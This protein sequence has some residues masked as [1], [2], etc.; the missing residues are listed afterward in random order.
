MARKEKERKLFSWC[1]PCSL[2]LSMACGELLGGALMPYL[3]LLI[4]VILPHWSA[5]L[6]IAFN[7]L[8][9]VPAQSS[10][11]GPRS[12]AS[13]LPQDWGLSTRAFGQRGFLKMQLE[14]GGV[15]QWQSTCFAC[16]RPWAQFQASSKQTEKVYGP[17][18]QLNRLSICF[19]FKN[20]CLS[21]IVPEIL[22]EM[23][24]STDLGAPEHFWLWGEV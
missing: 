21:L 9:P 19:A 20:L 22:P 16:V 6:L 8:S 18:R 5:S 2:R 23:T 24:P 14:A 10:L 13:S 4:S 1:S 17:D 11:R 7:S 3:S 12:A 15:D